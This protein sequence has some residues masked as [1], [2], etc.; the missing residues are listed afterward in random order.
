LILK[1]FLESFNFTSNRVWTRS[2]FK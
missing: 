2:T 1:G